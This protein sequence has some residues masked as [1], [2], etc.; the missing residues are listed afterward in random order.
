MGGV[1]RSGYTALRFLGSK[2][3]LR[4]DAFACD[5][6]QRNGSLLSERILDPYPRDDLSSHELYGIIDTICI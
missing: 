3:K 5:A 6:G 2:N 4:Q 1:T